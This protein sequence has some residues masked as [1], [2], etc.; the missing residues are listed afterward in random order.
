LFERAWLFKQVRRARNDLQLF[1]TPEARE[2]FLIQ[3]NDK[4]VG[5]ADDE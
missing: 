2:G 3:F 1:F 4:L 5:S